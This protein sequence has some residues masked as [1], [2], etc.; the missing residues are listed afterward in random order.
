MSAQANLAGFF[1][2]TEN[3]IWNE[4][5]LWQPVPVHTLPNSLDN[6]LRPRYGDRCPKYI[7]MYDWYMT[8][9][10][11]ALEMLEKHGH[12]IP[13]WERKSGWE[14]KTIEDVFSIYKRLI[15]DR[16]AGKP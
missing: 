15:A 13:Y 8:K 2:P 1:M 12:L 4:Q 7:E 3:E 16:D 10:P 5:I 9:S 11:E 14:I 6:I